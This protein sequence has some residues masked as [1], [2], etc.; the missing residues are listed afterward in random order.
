MV[1]LLPRMQKKG[2]QV[3]LCIFDGTRTPF[4]VQLENSGINFQG[5]REGSS[6]FNPLNVFRLRCLMC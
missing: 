1:D 2:H 4:F 5:F 6:V 3:E